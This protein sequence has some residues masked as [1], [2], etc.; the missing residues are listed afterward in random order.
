MPAMTL[1]DPKIDTKF[2]CN[3][4]GKCHKISPHRIGQDFLRN[5]TEKVNPSTAA[6][7][8]LQADALPSK[9]V[10]L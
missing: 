10:M 9:I 5:V 7:T 3:L 2:I 8:I 6:T 4:C 1:K